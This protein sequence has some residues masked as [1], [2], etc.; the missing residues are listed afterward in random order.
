[1]NLEASSNYIYKAV[2]SLE[3]CK[4]ILTFYNSFPEADVYLQIV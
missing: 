4:D 2:I 1:M 3:L